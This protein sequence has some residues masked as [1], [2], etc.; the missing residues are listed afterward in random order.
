MLN[1]KPAGV[2]CIQ[3]T[4]DNQCLLFGKPERPAVCGNLMPSK[5]M[6]CN[7]AEEAIALLTQLEIATAPNAPA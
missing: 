7:T 5:E 1:G 2:R 6:C 3:L 4:E